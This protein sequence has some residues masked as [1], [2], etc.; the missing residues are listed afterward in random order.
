[1][2]EIDRRGFLRLA[3]AA[4]TGAAGA[5][6]NTTLGAGEIAVGKELGI[7]VGNASFDN[8]EK[9]AC[10]N[11]PNPKACR[12]ELI[13]DPQLETELLFNAPLIEEIIFRGVPSM[14]LSAY[15]NRGNDEAPHPIEAFVNG[16]GGLRMNRREAIV[17]GVTAAA[18]GLAHNITEKGIDTK[19]VPAPQFTAGLTNW[20]LQRKFGFFSNFLSHI[21]ANYLAKRQYK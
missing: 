4:G 16:S 10:G 15:E 21:G 5:V 19:H 17:G 8:Q 20:Y 18:F 3:I 11:N 9:K 1:M 13:N 14:A 12:E 6:V 2:T 7:S